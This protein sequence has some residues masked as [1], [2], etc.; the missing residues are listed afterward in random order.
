[1]K[2][3]KACDGNALMDESLERKRGDNQDTPSKPRGAQNDQVSVSN[4]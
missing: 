3:Q 1:M 2:R 4:T